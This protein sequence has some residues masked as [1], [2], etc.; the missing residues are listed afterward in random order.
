VDA[1]LAAAAFS[2]AALLVLIWVVVGV[3]G[4]GREPVH[5][6]LGLRRP[7]RGRLRRGVKVLFAGAAAFA[8]M[9]VAISAVWSLV[10][11]AGQQF[12][13]QP[14]ARRVAQ[15]DSPW[16]V[17]LAVLVAVVV[18]SPAE[19]VLYRSVLYLPLRRGL[20][21]TGAALVVALIFGLAHSYWWG[22]PNLIVLSLTLTALFEYTG[23]LWAPIMAHSAYNALVIVVLRAL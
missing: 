17:A 2:R 23:T 22:M 9:V 6:L 11:R 15:T 20:G 3:A 19:E 12:P 8:G 18:A 21:V 16:V 5:L 10:S 4:R 14:L 7:T 13:M 1:R